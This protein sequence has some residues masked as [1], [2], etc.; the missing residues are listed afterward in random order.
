MSRAYVPQVERL[1]RL[2][3]L[4]LR[5]GV[6]F[7]NARHVQA[8]LGVSWATAKRDARLLRQFLRDLRQ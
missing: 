1:M 4:A 3:I 7:K 5:E 6:E 8:E 2:A